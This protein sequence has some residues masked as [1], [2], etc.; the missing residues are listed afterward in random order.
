MI[1]L[2]IACLTNDPYAGVNVAVKG[3]ILAQQKTE[4]VGLL[5]IGYN[6]KATGIHH[7][8][9]GKKYRWVAK[10]PFPFCKPDIVVFHEVYRLQYIYLSKEIRLLGVPYI[11][12]PHGSLTE[13]AQSNKLLKKKLGNLL[14]F[15][16]FIYN[17][18]AIQCLSL[19]EKAQTSFPVRKFIGT[20]GIDI[21]SLRQKKHDTDLVRFVYIG[22]LDLK[23]K[24]LDILMKAIFLQRD[25]LKQCNC[26][27]DLY[28]P[29]IGET[30]K[31]LKK[32]IREYEILSIV[33]I[34]NPIHGQKKE[35]ML[36]ERLI[37]TFHLRHI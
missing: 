27:F 5:N 14:L 7:V 16:E 13:T 33:E 28:G 31:I 19:R 32:M 30:V 21:H 12:F 18:S 26:H 4:T 11:V 6:R 20:N 25:K 34:H 15:N 10:L 8:F 37:Q 2:H 29:D 22:R 35:Q 17:A 1:I 36:I 3:H 23:I 9:S 24:G